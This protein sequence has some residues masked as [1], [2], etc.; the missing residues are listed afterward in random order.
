MKGLQQAI[1]RGT[2]PVVQEP[3][4]STTTRQFYNEDR[5]TN[6]SQ[7]RYLCY[8]LQE[9]GLLVKYYHAFAKNRKTDPTGYATLQKTLG[10]TD[11]PKFQKQWERWVVA[12]KYGR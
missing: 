12:L 1:A 5:G 3:C 10:V 7:A 9:K 6:Y 11:V 8:Y 2:V 4:A